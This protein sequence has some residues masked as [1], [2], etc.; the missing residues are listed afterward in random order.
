MLC[1]RDTPSGTAAKPDEQRRVEDEI[2]S[3]VSRRKALALVRDLAA[4]GPR[5]GGTAKGDRAAKLIAGRMRDLGL[6]V[7]VIDDP[8][9]HVHEALAWSVLTDGRPV[10]SAHPW[11]NAPSI[12]PSTLTLAADPGPMAGSP[13]QENALRGAAVITSRGGHADLI[14]S[15][16]AAILTDFPGNEDRYA[17]WAFIGEQPEGSRVPVFGVS[18][19]DGERMRDALR[20]GD[21]VRIAVTLEARVGSGRPRTVVGTLEGAGAMAGR[22]IV[23]CAHGD[24]DGGGPGADDNASGE[25]ATLEVA[26]ALIRAARGGHLPAS[27]PR[28]LFMIWGKEYHSSEAWVRANGETMKGLIAVM[29]YDQVGTGARRSAL[30]YEGNDIAANARLLRTIESVAVDHA[31]YEG[32]WKEHT[33]CPSMGGTDAFA[34][35][36]E[37]QGGTADGNLEV[38]ATTIFTAA[39]DREKKVAQPEAWRSPGWPRGEDVVIDYSRYYHSPAD[40]PANTTEAEPHNIER[41]ARLVVLTIRRLML[42]QP[43]S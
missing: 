3:F 32:Y 39:W 20:R 31:G 6:T 13:G 25:A 42:A 15:G 34:F 22:T 43:G 24:S 5:T 38:A 35:L 7:A 28:V 37:S 12:P 10:A 41:A 27:R 11:I 18:F 2:A 26:R 33:S 8:E 4:L 36:S 17:D 21:T 30:Y 40:T 16:A 29:N 9:T 1:P 14:A 19:H 23:V